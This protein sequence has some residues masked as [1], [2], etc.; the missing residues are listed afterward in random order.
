MDQPS[1]SK[2]G[3]CPSFDVSRDRRITLSVYARVLPGQR[4]PRP[5]ALAPCCTRVVGKR[6]ANCEQ[7]CENPWDFRAGVGIWCEG[8]NL[9]TAVR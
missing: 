9:P 7:A 5:G 1:P 8:G 3:G 6:L 4:R 2:N